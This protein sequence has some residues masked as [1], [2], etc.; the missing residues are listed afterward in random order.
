MLRALAGALRVLERRGDDGLTRRE[1]RAVRARSEAYVA[2]RPT[3]AEIAA[4]NLL[5]AVRRNR[6]ARDTS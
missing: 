3:D 2:W 5:L 1:R 4:L 6:R